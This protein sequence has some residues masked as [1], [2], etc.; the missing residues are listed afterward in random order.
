MFIASLSGYIDDLK[1]SIA[2]AKGIDL[3]PPLTIANLTQSL[4]LHNVQHPN[5][6]IAQALLET[7][8]FTSRV[9]LEYSNPFDLRRPLDGSYYHF[10][11]WEESV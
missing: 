6:V 5:I 10:N 3:V 11:N 1:A 2:V 9:C 8:Y 7:G 4:Q